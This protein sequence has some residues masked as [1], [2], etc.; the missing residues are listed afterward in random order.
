[1][2]YKVIPA[3]DIYSLTLTPGLW[4]KQGVSFLW[5]FLFETPFALRRG[6]PLRHVCFLFSPIKQIGYM[7][8]EDDRRDPL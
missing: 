3:F 1:M 4:D 2:G 5:S 7:K 8:R 6:L